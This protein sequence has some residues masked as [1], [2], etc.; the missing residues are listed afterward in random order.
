MSNAA[1]QVILPTNEADRKKILDAMQE[2]SNSYTRIESEQAFI[3]DVVE[4]ISKTFNLPKPLLN[5]LSRV[6]HKGNM[7]E[8]AGKFEEFVDLYESL[9]NLKNTNNSEVTEE[10]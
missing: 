3:K 1:S 7:D 10:S 8:E 2:I 4:D 5:R 9:V 6:L